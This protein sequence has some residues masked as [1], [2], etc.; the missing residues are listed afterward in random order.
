MT[1]IVIALALVAG[2]GGCKKE[3][4]S[5]DTGLVMA[6]M[7]EFADQMCRC[8]DKA[9]ADTVQEAMTK[10]SVDMA[11]KAGSTRDER[12]DEATMKKMTEIGQ[13]YAECMTQAFQSAVEPPPPPAPIQPALPAPVASPATVEQL[14]AS[15]REWARGEHDQLRVVQL[16]LYYI[17][18][19]GAVDPDSGKVKIELGGA[20]QIADDPKRKTGAP[21]LPAASQPTRC[22]ELSW[23]AAQ[24]WKKLKMEACYNAAAP[25]PRCTV[26]TIWKRAIDAGAPADALAVLTLRENANRRWNFKVSDE[27]RKVAIDNSYDDDCELAVEKP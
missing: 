1:R 2:L 27:P 19:D 3:A 9:C 10:W 21:I 15:A 12:P 5:S 13:K 8:K 18:A 14:L 20:S 4:S 11:A 22:F 7:T 24:G 26:Q 23:T 6:K 16:D 25:F 17:G